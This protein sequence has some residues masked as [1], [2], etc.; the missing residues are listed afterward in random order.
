LAQSGEAVAEKLLTIAKL[1]WF[2]SQTPGKE[3]V[4]LGFFILA[5][6]AFRNAQFKLPSKSLWDTK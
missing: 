2:L 6:T 3:I 5:R 1:L 4:V